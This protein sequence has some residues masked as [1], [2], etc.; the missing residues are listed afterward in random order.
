MPMAARAEQLREGKRQFPEVAAELLALP[1]EDREKSRADFDQE[2]EDASASR[3]QVQLVL[4][5]LA[6]SP[7]AIKFLRDN[8]LMTEADVPRVFDVLKDMV[9]QFYALYKERAPE[10]T[11]LTV[12][13][14]LPKILYFLT[15]HLDRTTAKS[16]GA[17]PQMLGLKEDNALQIVHRLNALFGI[18]NKS[19]A[20]PL[21]W[22]RTEEEKLERLRRLAA[23]VDN[24]R[25]LTRI[26]ALKALGDY[27]IKPKR[28]GETP[29][30]PLSKNR[31]WRERKEILAAIERELCF[32]DE[33]VIQ[34][35][36]DFAAS[37]NTWA[38]CLL[39]SLRGE[40]KMGD[41]EG[42]HAG[43]VQFVRE[44]VAFYGP[45]ALEG[46]DKVLLAKRILSEIPAPDGRKNL[47]SSIMVR[48]AKT[49]C[50]DVHPRDAVN[51][52]IWRLRTLRDGV[53]GLMQNEY[54]LQEDFIA[55]GVISLE[56]FG[57]HYEA[58]FPDDAT[59]KKFHDFLEKMTEER[60][61][62]PSEKNK[63]NDFLFRLE[64]F[65][66]YGIFLE[67][68]DVEG[69]KNKIDDRFLENTMLR[70]TLRV[71]RGR[72]RVIKNLSKLNQ[73]DE[74][75]GAGHQLAQF[76]T[77]LR[78][79]FRA[80]TWLLRYRRDGLNGFMLKI[81]REMR[82]MEDNMVPYGSPDEE[83]PCEKTDLDWHELG[84]GG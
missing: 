44:L 28:D 10:G 42:E 80:L 37:G 31:I 13:K 75:D 22:S 40:Q 67:K 50:R 12:E 56:N 11:H 26:A 34:R 72:A 19:R 57:Q 38:Q 65:L 64:Y 76:L 53:E 71:I 27:R 16:S 2:L 49:D 36:K 79:P 5:L 82:R 62:I 30:K 18:E 21:L 1:A 51:P 41:I 17:V 25:L 7:I 73:R 81:K 52:S 69:A 60:D 46:E 39:Q 48:I 6:G 59:R 23:L 55:T 8:E 70:E 3:D 14:S 58:L 54:I 66:A 47:L 43:L 84:G 68:D 29:E 15:A 45:D 32:T 24:E 74:K 4:Q 77:N 35:I 83:V 61:S 20:Q 33:K 78:F 63:I 9:I